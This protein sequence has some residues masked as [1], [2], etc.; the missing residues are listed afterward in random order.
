M[1]LRHL[2]YFCKKRAKGDNN[3]FNKELEVRLDISKQ[4]RNANSKRVSLYVDEISAIKQQ[5]KD[6]HTNRQLIKAG[7]RESYRMRKNRL[8]KERRQKFATT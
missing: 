1:S 5:R 7:E 3:L 2:M 4:K 8:N 6:N